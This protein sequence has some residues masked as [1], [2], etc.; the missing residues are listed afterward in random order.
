M[1]TPIPLSFSSDQTAD[2]QVQTREYEDLGTF[3]KVM[4]WVGIV[5]GMSVL[6]VLY[7]VYFGVPLV[8]DLIFGS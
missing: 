1:S 3:G 6:A 2:V 4:V 5:V 8:F 7:A